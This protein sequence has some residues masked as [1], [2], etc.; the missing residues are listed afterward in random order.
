M[1]RRKVSFWATK[2]IRTKVSFVTKDGR[3]LTFYAKIPRKVKVRSKN[4]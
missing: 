1:I 2:P 4:G 3:K